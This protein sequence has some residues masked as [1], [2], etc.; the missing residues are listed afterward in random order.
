MHDARFS[1]QGRTSH[2]E[3]VAISGQDIESLWQIAGWGSFEDSVAPLLADLGLTLPTGYVETLRSR[4]HAVWRIAPDRILLSGD[5]VASATLGDDLALL[6]LSDSRVRLVLDGPGSAGLLAR[7]LSL[8]FSTSAFPPG[9]FRQSG[10]YHV[11][12]LIE[13]MTDTRFEMMVPRTWAG[14]VFNML[15][16]HLAA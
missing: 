3:H 10:L 6:D 7:V 9:Q 8:D 15:D 16:V 13:R 4:D 12:A 14:S 5:R 2:D 11:A 1:T